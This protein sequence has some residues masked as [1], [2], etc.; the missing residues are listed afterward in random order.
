MRMNRFSR[1]STVWRKEFADTL[2]DRRT[3]IAMVLVPMVLYPALMLGSLQAFELQVGRLKQE[4]YTI[5]V[6]SP[7]VQR[8][9]RTRIIDAD[10][11]RHAAAVGVPAEDLPAVVEAAEQAR[12]E[13]PVPGDGSPTD[14]AQSDV[15]HAPPPYRVEVFAN[16]QQAVWGGEAH[17]GL[18]VE[19][20]DLPTP[21]STGSARV[22]L[23]MDQAEIRSQIAASG[24]DAILK[25][26]NARFVERRLKDIGLGREFVEPLQLTQFSVAT[27]EKLGGSILG[28]VVAL[29]L[30]I[31]TITGAIYPA[32]DLTAGE[33]ERGTLETLMAAPVPTVDLIAGKFVV[34]ASI[35][36]LS[37][38]LNLLSIGGTIY[39]GGLGD[40]LTR[41]NQLVI[42]LHTLPLVL[43]VL[44]PL[45]IMFSAMLLAVCSFAR[46]FKE[47]QNYVMPVMMVALI[48]AVI[49][50]LPGTELKGPLLIMP[51]TNIVILTR[52]LFMGEIDRVAIIWVTLS[53]CIYAGAA[54]AVA[55]KLFGQEAVLF[56]D[57][58]SIKTLFRRR[59]Y[60]IADAPSA[61]Q[62]F[63]LVA[64]VYSLNFFVQQSMLKTGVS[65]GSAAHLAGVALTLALLFAALPIAAALY[66][67]VRVAPALSLTPP[68]PG[69]LLAG[70]CFGA[71]TW[72]LSLAWLTM[73]QQ[74]L[75]I[76]PELAEAAAPLEQQLRS[77]PLIAGLFFIALVPGFCEE[78]FFRGYTL[79]GMRGSMGKVGAV[80]VVAFAF[81]VSHY[82]VHRLAVTMALGTLL[83]LLVVQYRSIWPAMLAHMMHNSMILLVAR[84]DGLLPYLRQWGF[85]DAETQDVFPPAVWLIA[86]AT[87]VVVGVLLCLLGPRQTRAASATADPLRAAGQPAQPTPPA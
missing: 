87:L 11:A 43:V 32:I 5:A 10:L 59:F 84:E 4:E 13:R 14:A 68:K 57:S 6:A 17:V 55:A 61:A 28:Q 15:R 27:P 67:R 66:M 73:Q 40:L 24:L 20:G 77:L 65:P 21:H 16:V 60:K 8:W 42:P 30:V 38:A 82:S 36:M 45:A 46:S 50:V 63:L 80:L 7:E 56:A 33:R 49:G 26:A 1:I 12:D 71:S 19:G 18:F 25:R 37:A 2:R 39:L 3:V 58:T 54:V 41:G 34:V 48:P 52:E 23:V 44:I 75:P 62:A 53:T 74:I 81:A 47:A 70:L 83:G 69:A 86:A 76:S 35:G 51:V 64:G 72:V 9:L 22:T 79:S 29:V 85:V 78:I 31:M